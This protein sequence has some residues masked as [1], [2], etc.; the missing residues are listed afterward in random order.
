MKTILNKQITAF[1]FTAFLLVTSS[2]AQLNYMRLAQNDF[3][4]A[5]DL[6]NQALMQNELTAGISPQMQAYNLY[7]S[8]YG[9]ITKALGKK[10]ALEA[11]GLLGS[12]YTIK[13][14]C[15]WKMKYYDQAKESKQLAIAE[16][17][18]T[19]E[20]ERDLAVMIALDGL[21]EIEK[22]TDAIRTQSLFLDEPLEARKPKLEEAYRAKMMKNGRS[23]L[24]EAVELIQKAKSQAGDGAQ[25]KQYLL[26]SQLAAVRTWKKSL[27]TFLRGTEL[28]KTETALFKEQKAVYKKELKELAGE[29]SPVYAYWDERL[30]D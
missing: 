26:V 2:C 8:S 24:L 4:A 25:V 6:S 14:L 16:L 28:Y 12:A 15:E 17:R 1:F 11:D 29:D 18:K 30:P 13:A 20:L 19:P 22:A 3:T 7:R 10:S 23:S 5:A 9:H 27:D 21:I